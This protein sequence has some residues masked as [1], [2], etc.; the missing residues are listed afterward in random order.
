[1]RWVANG[2]VGLSAVVAACAG[3]PRPGPAPAAG[4]AGGEAGGG[5]AAA[6]GGGAAT[7]TSAGGTGGSAERCAPHPQTAEPVEL[8]AV[9]EELPDPVGGKI[10]IG[11]YHLVAARLYVGAEGTAGPTGKWMQETQIWSLVDLHT[12]LDYGDGEGER[13]LELAYD[14]GGGTGSLS[15]T[16]LCPEPLSTP[17]KG[18][19][20]HDG[21]LVLFAPSQK[22]AWE[23]ALVR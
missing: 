17:W 15:T 5:G 20:S 1:M 4:G 16:V 8:T 6:E 14:L 23:Y 13:R 22:I 18:Y 3:E 7:T 11:T 10:T 12:V 19:S 9:A 2:V 21:Q